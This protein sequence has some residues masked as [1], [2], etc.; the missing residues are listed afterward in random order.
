MKKWLYLILVSCFLGGCASG[1]MTSST[2]DAKTGKYET[3]KYT[4]FFSSDSMPLAES[5]EFRVSVVITRRVEPLSHSFLTAMGGLGP[6]DLNSTATAVVHFK[7]DS[8][9]T[10]KINLKSLNIFNT[11]NLTNLDEVILSPGDRFSTKEIKT[12]VSTYNTEF[13][14]KLNYELNG[15]AKSTVFSM[16]RQTS[17]DFRK[18]KQ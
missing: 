3:K 10:L 17:E 14:L 2:Y 16:V 1:Y 4:P 6:D 9:E 13:D 15:I 12:E 11:E 18:K 5:A 8:D 7:N